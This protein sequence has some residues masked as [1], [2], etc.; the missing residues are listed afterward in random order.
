MENIGAGGPG[1]VVRRVTRDELAD[2]ARE[3]AHARDD[4]GGSRSTALLGANFLRDLISYLEPSLHLVF[5]SREIEL[6]RRASVTP[7]GHPL[8]LRFVLRSDGT[9]VKY[10]ESNDSD[11]ADPREFLGEASTMVAV[12]DALAG[13]LVEEGSPVSVAAAEEVRR[14]NDLLTPSEEERD[15]GEKHP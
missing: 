5:R 15:H 6:A 4:V 3:L 9:L 11:P 10:D 13:A 8:T 2:Q 1:N 7:G 12:L 14:L